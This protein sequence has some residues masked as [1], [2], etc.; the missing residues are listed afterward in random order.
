MGRLHDCPLL[1]QAEDEDEVDSD[2]DDVPELDD[3][4]GKSSGS[5]GQETD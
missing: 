5:L 3:N 1:P 4:D 2:D